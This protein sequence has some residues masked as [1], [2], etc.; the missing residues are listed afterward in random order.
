MIL[1]TTT[2]LLSRQTRLLPLL[3]P[4]RHVSAFPATRL[5]APQSRNFLKFLRRG[6]AVPVDS[7]MAYPER[8]LVYY[9]GKRT[10]YLGTLKLYTVLL[11]SYCGLIIAPSLVGSDNSTIVKDLGLGDIELPEWVLP[12]GVIL[13]S[14]APLVLMQWL[15][16]VNPLLVTGTRVRNGD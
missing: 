2:R 10:V 8:L 9:A 5:P 3:H 15:T 6:P 16:Y 14:L 7:K 11:F 12:V 4:L 1:P 13:G